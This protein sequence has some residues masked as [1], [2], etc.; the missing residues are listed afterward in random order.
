MGLV[1]YFCSPATGPNFVHPNDGTA[2]D[3]SASVRA[4]LSLCA[5]GGLTRGFVWKNGSEPFERA[6][7]ARR[8]SFVDPASVKHARARRAVMV[9][10]SRHLSRWHA[11]LRGA[12]TDL[13]RGR[14][15]SHR[16]TPPSN[17][18]DIHTLVGT[19][20]CLPAIVDFRNF[21]LKNG[22][23]ERNGGMLLVG[24]E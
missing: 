6:R 1:G 20:F 5:R 2:R 11:G 23:L 16:N 18:R 3:V 19:L 12:D 4:L 17:N 10:P 8:N 13:S 15:R 22:G 7:R 24:S 9:I 21:F 14:Q